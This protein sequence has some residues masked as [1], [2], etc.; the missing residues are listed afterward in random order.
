MKKLTISF[1][2]VLTVIVM[3]CNDSA[4]QQKPVETTSK[5]EQPAAADEPVKQVKVTFVNVDAG[6]ANHMKQL[7]D[8]YL[9][10]KNALTN[11][12][13]ADAASAAGNMLVAAKGFDKSLLS[14][15]QKKVYDVHENNLKER[16]GQIASNS[17]DIEQ[18]RDQFSLLSEDMYELVKAFGAGKPIYHEYCP[19]AKNDK[20]AMWLSESKAIRNPYFGDKMMECGSVEEEINN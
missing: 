19:M 12:N 20:G 17:K 8:G 9:S 6:V 14:A 10:L 11:T 7:T 3:A 1:M 13:A 16:V 2:A 15:D 4:D 5:T 18:Q